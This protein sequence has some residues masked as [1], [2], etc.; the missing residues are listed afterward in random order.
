MI[1]GNRKIGHLGFT[2]REGDQ[3]ILNRETVIQVT[4]A[5][6][7]YVKLSVSAPV[8]V[9]VSRIIKKSTDTHSSIR[10]WRKET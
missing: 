10:S 8:D 5:G 4:K 6:Q 7:T 3:I 2:L 9:D 1:D